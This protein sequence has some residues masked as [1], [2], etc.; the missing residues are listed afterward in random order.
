MRTLLLILGSVSLTACS[1]SIRRPLAPTD[2]A[3]QLEQITHSNVHEFDPAVSPD[4]K[5]LAYEVAASPDAMPH[6]EVMALA[7]A[8]ST[9]P[10][11]VEYSSNETMGLEPTWMPDGSGLIF[12]SRTK[13][14]ARALMQTMGPTIGKNFLAAAGDPYLLAERPAVS[15]DGK[16][17]AM[18]LVNIEQY[19]S[20]WRSS[21]HF[22]R[23]LG[24]SDLIGT[25]VNVIGAGSDPAFSPD[26]KQIAFARADGRHTHL[27]VA[28]ADGTGIRQI[29]DGAA[30]D[31]EPSWSPDGK[32]IVFTSAHGDADHYV[33]ANLFASLADGAG[34]VQLTEGD[35]FASRPTWAKDG[36]VYF[37]VNATDRFH[38]WRIR[39][40]GS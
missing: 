23:A 40:R 19:Q 21:K 10:A 1:A 5:E 35:R 17:M 28:N 9:A 11:K 18:S 15:P 25:G 27:F 6:V 36:F 8:G 37:H 2:A 12:V 39:L 22:D 16:T 4:G 14:S 26:G 30:D 38:I 33:Q 34:I 7:D 3:T 31:L 13:D 29:T 20:G 32:Y 24:I